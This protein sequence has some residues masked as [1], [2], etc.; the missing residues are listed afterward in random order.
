MPSKPADQ[1][2]SQDIIPS[3]ENII[4]SKDG[5]TKKTEQILKKIKDIPKNHKTSPVFGW[6]YIKF[7]D[8]AY[9]NVK[10]KDQLKA[11]AK[12]KVFSD[13][14][15]N[16]LK[17]IYAESGKTAQE[18]QLKKY[19][20]GN[21]DY[22]FLEFSIIGTKITTEL[23]RFVVQSKSR[24]KQEAEKS[25]AEFYKLF[26]KEGV[27][28]IK[29][30][31][32]KRFGKGTGKREALLAHIKNAISLED[33]RV[34]LNELKKIDSVNY[35]FIENEFN[36]WAIDNVIIPSLEKR[37]QVL[38]G[39]TEFLIGQGIIKPENPKQLK[40]PIE[41]GIPPVEMATKIPSDFPPYDN[42][43]KRDQPDLIRSVEKK[44]AINDH[45][46]TPSKDDKIF[47]SKKELMD[48]LST[49]DNGS[50]KILLRKRQLENIYLIASLED[51]F[52]ELKGK[53]KSWQGRFIEFGGAIDFPPRINLNTISEI[54]DL[55]MQVNS[56]INKGELA[57]AARY[58]TVAFNNIKLFFDLLDNYYC[59][60][61]EQLKHIVGVLTVV[62]TVSFAVLDV[63]TFKLV[64]PLRAVAFVVIQRLWEQSV[65]I[66]FNQ[67]TSIDI[68]KF[69]FDVGGSVLLNRV[70]AIACEK[71][72]AK[73]GQ[74]S[75]ETFKS[76]GLKFVLNNFID[77]LNTTI[78]NTI[79][80]ASS[81]D[82]F[83]ENVY[84]NTISEQNFIP[85]LVSI[86][87]NQPQVTQILNKNKSS[88]RPTNFFP[89][90]A[91][92]A[93][94][95]VDP[96]P[97]PKPE[98][99]DT[100]AKA[101]LIDTGTGTKVGDRA[102]LGREIDSKITPPVK[103]ADTPD[104]PALPIAKKPGRH[105]RKPPT[106]PRVTPKPR[107]KT[108]IQLKKELDELIAKGYFTDHEGFAEIKK[109]AKEILDDLKLKK[110]TEAVAISKLQGLINAKRELDGELGTL[111]VTMTN[112]P[113]YKIIKTVPRRGDNGAHI[114]D[115]VLWNQKTK[116][117][118]IVEAKS[119]RS[120]HTGKV[121]KWKFKKKGK[122]I[123]KEK[124]KDELISQKEPEWIFQ[125]IIELS[126]HK[127]GKNLA[128]KLFK[129]AKAGKIDFLLVKG[130]HPKD[131]SKSV[132]DYFISKKYKDIIDFDIDEYFRNL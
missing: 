88:L 59:R 69:A 35:N 70:G 43:E 113:N 9:S 118:L 98:T 128:L 117:Y 7:Y 96:T 121:I 23:E 122:T 80:G 77:G 86:S 103:P 72:L 107:P 32:D 100:K 116:S 20:S 67:R 31:L 40:A 99:F 28:A 39:N 22:K 27:A 61:Q 63:L 36:K 81:L 51:Y 94:R 75:L 97:A 25:G 5:E 46:I 130:G 84:K 131:S 82:E 108:A 52:N 26:T 49:L 11:S 109:E 54:E 12:R 18:E 111:S 129:A 106:K 45:E 2:I 56:L 10:T 120:T 38:N 65:E 30:I 125:R 123:I 119:K 48:F 101:P 104:M 66:S 83:I 114:L 17:F 74:A 95:L 102:T 64:S 112:Y 33:A 91:L 78:I 24:S 41:S 14:I 16:H 76:A 19:S 47:K 105:P 110:I 126:L 93:A 42:D 124:V 87:L 90:S 29:E 4:L 15:L 68:N 79:S 53:S 50:F 89:A 34:F 127:N 58:N 92:L 3:L 44:C 132:K 60:M 73:Y 1:Y 71:I 21:G 37:I 13:I 115:V 8:L 62:K 57:M 55:L 85:N 6:L